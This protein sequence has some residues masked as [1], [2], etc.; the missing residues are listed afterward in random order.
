MN[1]NHGAWGSL[2]K[3]SPTVYAKKGYSLLRERRIFFLKKVTQKFY[4][5]E[6]NVCFNK[7]ILSYPVPFQSIPNIHPKR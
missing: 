3:C 6:K 7:N 2:S 5:N 4:V 1:L